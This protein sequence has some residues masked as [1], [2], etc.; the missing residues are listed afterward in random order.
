[1]TDYRTVDAGGGL[2]YTR[3][4]SKTFYDLLGEMAE[5]H[6]R[7]SHDYANNDDPF[8]NYRFAG[9]V[10]NLFSH[11]PH[12]AGFAGRLAEKIY[13]LS[14]LEGGGKTPL[15]ESILDTERDIAVITT[16]W[17]A[18]RRDDRTPVSASQMAVTHGVNEEALSGMITLEPSLTDDGRRQMISYLQ[19][20]IRDNQA[21]VDRKSENPSRR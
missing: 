1:M 6:S 11:S 5:L 13:R 12:D 18:C 7:K 17:M 3:H 8:G 4:G 10:A 14:V 19:N 16:L 15:N 2:G 20:C 21:T 9:L